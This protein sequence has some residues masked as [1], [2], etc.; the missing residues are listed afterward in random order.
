LENVALQAKSSQVEISL[1]QNGRWYRIA[2]RDNGLGFDPEQAS[3][4]PGLNMLVERA[5][6]AGAVLRSSADRVMGLKSC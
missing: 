2:I 3:G 6:A 4:H 1:Q 5:E